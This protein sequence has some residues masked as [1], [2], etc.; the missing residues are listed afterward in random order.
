[1]LLATASPLRSDMGET[2]SRHVDAIGCQKQNER[3]KKKISRS[4]GKVVCE[5][6]LVTV[7]RRVGNVSVALS[8]VKAMGLLLPAVLIV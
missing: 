1:M 8:A 4:Q 7:N 6:Q 3:L 2:M 5:S